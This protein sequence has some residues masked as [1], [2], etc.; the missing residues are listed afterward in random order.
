[1]S[2]KS[3][4]VSAAISASVDKGGVAKNV[5]CAIP[6]SQSGVVVR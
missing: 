5:G 1:V 4:F 6:L 3:A 2:T